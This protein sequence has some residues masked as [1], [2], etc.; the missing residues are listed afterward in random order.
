MNKKKLIDTCLE[1]LSA[2]ISEIQREIAQISED[3]QNET[4]S[5]MGDK[6]ET[7]REMIIQERTKLLDQ[8]S[9]LQKQKVAIEQMRDTLFK[10]VKNGALVVTKSQSYLISAALGEISFNGQKVFV[11]SQQAPIAKAMMSKKVGD[12]FSFH[13]REHQILEI[14]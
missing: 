11:I 3:A 9:I 2:R 5:S 14:Y 1:Q 6:Y 8:L 10:A 7:G 4:K 12:S 13:G